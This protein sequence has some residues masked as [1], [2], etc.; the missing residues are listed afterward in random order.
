MKKDATLIVLSL[1][2]SFTAHSQL[3]QGKVLDRNGD[4]VP[5]A[6]IVASD[7][8]RAVSANADGSFEIALSKIPE[9]LHISAVGFQTTSVAITDKNLT[10]SNFEII[11]VQS[12]ASISDVVVT[13]GYT[14]SRKK[15]I[16]GNLAIVSGE[17]LTEKAAGVSIGREDSKDDLTSGRSY[18]ETNEDVYEYSKTTSLDSA[19]QTFSESL[20]KARLI[21]AGELND[22]NKWK[23]WE[24]F[25][26]NDFKVWSEHWN[27]FATHRYCVQLRNNQFAPVIGKQVYL[28]N[29]QT[30]D[31]VWKAVTDVTG[32]AELWAGLNSKQKEAHYFI[33]CEDYPHVNTQ[34]SK[35]EDGINK[36]TLEAP[37][38]EPK[39]V[40]VA[41]VVDATGSMKDELEYLKLELED[42][43][44][45]T[46]AKFSNLVVNTAAVFYR[47]S[48][49]EYLT[50]HIDFNG[51]L[52]K[53]LN[54]IRLQK[55]DGGGDM[56]EAINSALHTALDSLKWSN[57]ARAKLLFLLLD[58]PPHDEAKNEMYQIIKQAAAS[59]IRIIP[60]VCSDADK[61]TEFL[62]RTIALATNGTYIFL[63]D[64]SGIGN[65]HMKPT[66][67]VY[68][69]ELLNNLLQR[70][71]QQMIYLN[72]CSDTARSEPVVKIPENL[73]KIK[74]SPNPTTGTV[75]MSSNKSFKEIYVAD[76]TGKILMKLDTKQK[77]LQ[78]SLSGYPNG[79]YL[80]KYVTED[81]QWG[82]E[83][84][85]VGR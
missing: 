64:H 12:T 24:D 22:F 57:N 67:D 36:I 79:T 68:T 8:L 16:T 34:A 78:F 61:S 50:R 43:L 51:D 65:E 21:T 58:A 11:L 47:D 54:F 60:I 17:A 48:G 49:D 59:G 19:S 80:I 46:F 66:T 70:L 20:P 30:K 76:Y 33:S 73:L 3:L 52:L 5:F 74:V 32:K 4:A 10:D 84:V 75:Y 41:F 2:F 53:A 82:A 45:R 23:M 7:K 62:M 69:V 72:T 31:T 77:N 26:K 81:N 44:K 63:T 25:S 56:P 15:D 38:G 29:A 35:F 18:D 37:C 42:I 14:V 28:I 85:A 1:L 27:L 6:T 40:E 55:A 71:I 13:T 83:K 39:L 9:T